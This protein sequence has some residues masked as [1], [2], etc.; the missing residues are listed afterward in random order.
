MIPAV[1]VWPDEFAARYRERGY[2]TGEALGEHV[3]RWAESTPDAIAVVDG[4]RRW[5]YA[6]LNSRAD[7][8][9]RGILA[10]GF[11][12]GDRVV[13][14][15]PNIAEFLSVVYGLYRTGVLPV[16]ALPAHRSSEITH[17]AQAA[18]AR[19]YVIPDMHAGFDY[20]KLA[21]DVRSN[22][23]GVEHVFVVGDAEEFTSLETL[24]ASGDPTAALPQ[25]SA[26]RV[27]FLQLSGGSTGLS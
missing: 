2:W 25:L 9:A 27:A 17:F 10:A 19:G 3:R 7:A 26:S 6:E 15:L 14:Q 24:A 23:P 11:V 13:V 21:R 5:S 12:A 8:I 18:E 4:E 20:R 1:Q 22:L 16:F